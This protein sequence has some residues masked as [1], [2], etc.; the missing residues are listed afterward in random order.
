MKHPADRERPREDWEWSQLNGLG[1]VE[2]VAFAQVDAM[3]AL[4]ARWGVAARRPDPIG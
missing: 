1:E 3:T 2:S 4:F